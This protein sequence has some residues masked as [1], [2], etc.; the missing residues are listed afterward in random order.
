MLI[1]LRKAHPE[2]GLPLMRVTASATGSGGV[3]VYLKGDVVYAQ[4]KKNRAV[5]DPVDVFEEGAL[6]ALAEN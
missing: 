2:T 6:S 5:W 4:N 1:P 3:V